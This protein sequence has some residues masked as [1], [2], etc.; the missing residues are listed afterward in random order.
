MFQQVS[1]R[2]GLGFKTFVL[3]KLFKAGH[4]FME[5][6]DKIRVRDLVS[7][8]SVRVGWSSRLDRGVYRG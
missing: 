2:N 5:S 1:K 7:G 4:T 3:R 8:G 6:W